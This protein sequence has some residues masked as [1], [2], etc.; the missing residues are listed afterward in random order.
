MAA[1]EQKVAIRGG[2]GTIDGTL[3]LPGVLVPGVLF[4]HGW[5]GA[6][7]STWRA[8]ARSPHSVARA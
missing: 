4:V 5:G 8:R 3:V 1:R 2:S 7:S 6:S